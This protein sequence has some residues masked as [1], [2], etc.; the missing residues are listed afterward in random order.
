MSG[1]IVKNIGR[2]SL[3]IAMLM[4]SV[5]AY[6]ADCNSSPKQDTSEA[7]IKQLE[8]Q[9]SRAFYTGDTAF[10]ECL[11]AANFRDVD[12]KGALADRVQDI[13]KAAKNVGKSWTYDPNKWQSSIFMH[14]HSAVATF[15]RGDLEHGTRG[16]DIY[17]YDGKHWHA[18][19]SQST[20]F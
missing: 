3:G 15:F 9:W 10:L 17:E 18:I 1:A 6:S 7:T 5:A 13:A 4:A 20:K 2:R 12:S 8:K 14:L 11:Y 16:T 19:F